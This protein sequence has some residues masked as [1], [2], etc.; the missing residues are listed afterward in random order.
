MR[1]W[2]VKYP[3]GTLQVGNGIIDS[4]NMTSNSLGKEITG[5][6]HSMKVTPLSGSD[7]EQ[8]VEGQRNAGKFT[9]LPEAMAISATDDVSN[10]ASQEKSQRWKQEHRFES[11]SLFLIQVQNFSRR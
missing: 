10:A 7:F 4:E 8:S 11:S 5:I 3:V 2:R 1:N 9:A 6:R